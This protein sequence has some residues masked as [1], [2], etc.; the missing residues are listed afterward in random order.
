MQN[1]FN[2]FCLFYYVWIIHKL[3]GDQ[4]RL[5]L[6]WLK[7]SQEIQILVL[8]G[9]HW[10]PA[11]KSWT[12][13]AASET[14]SAFRRKASPNMGRHGAQTMTSEPS[15]HAGWTTCC[16]ISC[17]PQSQSS[18]LAIRTV[19]SCSASRSRR[20]HRAFAEDPIDLPVPSFVWT[21]PQ[22]WHCLSVLEPGPC[23]SSLPAQA[24]P[25]PSLSDSMEQLTPG[26]RDALSTGDKVSVNFG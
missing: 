13:A 5:P 19:G 22:R 15:G 21:H 2:T 3:K 14:Q 26:T 25:H 23:P 1:S 12:K 9:V 11:Q 16:L 18:T 6:W 8:R 20:P 4:L 24:I 10:P 7:A 17:L